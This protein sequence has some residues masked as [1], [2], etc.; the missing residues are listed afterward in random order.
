MGKLA[1]AADDGH[2]LIAVEPGHQNVAENQVG[3]VV[4]DLGQGVKAVFGEQHLIAG[5]L[6]K[7]LGAAADGV[8]VIDD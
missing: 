2:G 3:L 5:L 7:N 1:A 8:A 6:E 4:V